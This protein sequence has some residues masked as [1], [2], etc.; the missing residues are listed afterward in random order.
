MSPSSN[1]LHQRC[2]GTP[3]LIVCS[4]SDLAGMS[5]GYHN[6]GTPQSGRGVLPT[7]RMGTVGRMTNL[8]LHLSVIHDGCRTVSTYLKLQ[9]T[10]TKV[11]GY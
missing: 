1:F 11:W 4:F 2:G 10:E 3:R 9:N 8:R 6:S 7:S 5:D